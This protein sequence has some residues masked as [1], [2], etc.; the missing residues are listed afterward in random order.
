VR[1][2]DVLFEAWPQ[3]REVFPTRAALGA[4]AIPQLLTALK[5]PAEGS[6]LEARWFATTLFLNRGDH[7]EVRP[8]PV[9]AQFAPVSGLSVADFDGDGHPDVFLAQNF[10]PVRPDEVPQDAGCGL[11]LRGTG[12][13]TFEPQS[14]DWSGI[15]VWGDARGSAIGD[16]DADGRPDLVVTQNGGA[17]RVFR[18]RWGRPG[19]SVRLNG[20]PENPRGVGAQL[21]LRAGDWGGPVQEVQAG[22]GWLS[23]D[24]PRRILTSDRVATELELRWPGR[25]AVRALIPAGARMLELTPDGK[26]LRAP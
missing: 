3:L 7:L 9:E 6:R 16:F 13:G 25:P 24:S 17:T 12:A 20:P 14:A 21:R 11:L 23:V 18:N 4:A 26:I 1:R 10:F 2:A 5:L 8:L 22:T 19:L 15:R